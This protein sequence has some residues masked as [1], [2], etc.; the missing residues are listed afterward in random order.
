VHVMSRSAAEQVEIAR[1][2]GICVFGETLAAAIG[3]DGTNYLH[4]CWR[5]AAGHVLSPP[6]RP[7]TDTPRILV[8]MLAK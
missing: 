1:K 3:T 4:K 6:L 7:D 8:D 5:H 2:R